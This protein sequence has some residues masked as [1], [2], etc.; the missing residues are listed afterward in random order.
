MKGHVLTKILTIW[1]K[2][3]RFYFTR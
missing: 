1:A 3:W 2:L